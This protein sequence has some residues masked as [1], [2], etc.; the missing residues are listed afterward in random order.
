MQPCAFRFSPP[1]GAYQAFGKKFQKRFCVSDLHFLPNH[2]ETLLSRNVKLSPGKR[3]SNSGPRL[4]KY[5]FGQ[6]FVFYFLS[7]TETGCSQEEGSK[8]GFV[9][10]SRT[11]GV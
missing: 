6:T 5:Y 11:Q 4:W 9:M 2:I 7:G 8:K 10:G 1:G 3:K